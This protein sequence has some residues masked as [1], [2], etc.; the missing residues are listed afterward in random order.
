MKIDSHQHF[1]KYHPVRDA[2]INEQMK[3]LQRDFLPEELK[4][5]MDE[6]G[7]Q[8]CVAVQAD[9]SEEESDFLLDLASR[10]SFL[11]GVVG[12]VDLRADD[13]SQKLARFATN[14]YFK[15]VRHIVQAEPD[16]RFILRDDFKRGI[17]AL[18][19]YKLTYDILVFPKHLG[20]VL[21]LVDQFPEQPFVIDHMAKPLIRDR[22]LSPWKEEIEELSKAPNVYCKVSGLITEANWSTWTADHFRP[23]LDVVFEVFGTDR[24]MFGSDW[25]VC[26]LAGSYRKV[27]TLLEDY[28][29]TL[30]ADAREKIWS[31]NAIDFY[32]LQD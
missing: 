6:C 30:S 7:V 17:A 3:V 28:T 4:R 25:P 14:P 15:G 13:V 8:G 19:E 31:N 24:L 27:V 18:S 10:H 9:Q 23:Y 26:K 21:E 11:R 20:A 29:Q 5:E 1:W 32:K 2:W 22:Q 16:D 12:W